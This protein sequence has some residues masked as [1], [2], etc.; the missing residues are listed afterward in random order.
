MRDELRRGGDVEAQR[1]YTG[2]DYVA[3]CGQKLRDLFTEPWGVDRPLRILVQETFGIADA[4]APTRIHRDERARGQPAVLLLP[5]E[6]VIHRDDGV[7]VLR[8]LA[9]D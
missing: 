3:F 4:R 9:F 7:G 2:A 6:H 5:R 1:V 8:R